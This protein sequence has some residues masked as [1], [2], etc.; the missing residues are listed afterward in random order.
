MLITTANYGSA[1]PFHRLG[2]SR[3]KLIAAHYSSQ[4]NSTDPLMVT[5]TVIKSD[6]IIAIAPSGNDSFLKE[7]ISYNATDSMVL[8][9]ANQKAYLYNTAVVVYEDMRLEA[10]Y[11]E[12][13]FGKNVL[14]SRGIKD[15][16]G[17]IIQKPVSTQAGEK[18]NAG[19]ITYNFKTKKGKIR[20]VITQQGDG[21]IH[22]RDIKKDSSN[23]YYVAHGKYTTCDLE[24]PH[25]YIGAEKIKVIPNDK[26]VT[27]AAQMYV[28]DVPTPLVLPFGYFPNKQGRASGILLPTYGESNQWGFFLKDGGFYFGMNEFIDLALRGDIYANGSFGGKAASNYAYRYH[29]N[30][31][32]N[33]GYSEIINGDKELPNT[34]RSNVFNVQW[35]HVQDPKANPNSRFSA[36]VNAGSSSY[37]KFNGNVNGSYLTNTLQSNIAYSKVLPGTPF[38]FSANARHSQNT[39]TKKIDIS[40]PELALTMNRIYPFKNNSRVGNKWYDKVGVSAT[41]N[42]RNEVHTYDSLLF[43]NTTVK[44]MQNGVRFAAPISTSLNVLKYFTFS[45][46]ISTGSTIYRQT[47]SKRYNIDSNR[48]YI[49]TVH[50]A[51][52]ANDFSLSASLNTRLYGDYFFRTK[53]LKQ[54]RHVATP[55]LGASYRPDFS[56]SQYGYYRDVQID[57]AGNTQQYS[58]FQNGI[59]GSPGAGRSGIISFGLNNTLEAKI[60]QKTDSGSVDKKVSL[61]DNFSGSVSYN[62]AVKQFNWS[63]INLNARTKLFKEIDVNT[64]ASFDPYQ[65]DS[66]GTRVNR[67]EWNRQPSR[68]I[69]EGRRIGRLTAAMLSISTS[70]NKDKLTK[71]KTSAN[72]NP[73]A[74]PVLIQDYDYINSHPNMYVDF[75]VPWNLSVYYNLNYSKPAFEKNVTQTVT[76]MGDLSLTKKW[77]LT[78]SSGYDLTNKKVTVTSINVYRD[79]HCWE[80]FFTWVPFGFRQSFSLNLNVKSA[81]L[82]DLK[83][84]RKKD[85]YDYQ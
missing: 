28:A 19:E 77:K 1:A 33:I 49:D 22:G 51:Q 8:D 9:M 76:F 81:M 63:N 68:T 55:S 70:L 44:Q 84:T 37:N 48:V 65:L 29:Y 7:K 36:N 58:I 6:T 66:A 10:G 25:Y 24:H 67:L 34:T 69:M 42:A 20:D 16:A 31:N 40:L 18:F 4:N 52:M 83:L 15:S 60:R 85:W 3:V 79:L 54:I 82:K 61:I 41:A 5:D 72:T 53:R 39:I 43:T 11:I 71:E 73:T 21:F 64:S 57:S 62:V 47:I 35:N 14:F 75:D 2:A 78:L 12:L 74:A 27:G 26:I 59:Y 30:G 56:E 46:T 17:N 45:P 32:F 23:V 50:V 13:D 38:N 80:M